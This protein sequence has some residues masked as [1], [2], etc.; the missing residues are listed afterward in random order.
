VASVLEAAHNTGVHV[1]AQAVLRNHVH[2]LVSYL[3]TT[4]LDGF[5]QHAKAE[6]ARRVNVARRDAQRLVWMV[7]YHVGSLSRDHVT[8]TRS[9]IA[10]QFRRHPDLI[11]N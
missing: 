10:R 5:V 4:A 2:V 3:P 8:A 6:A 9:Y 11:P 1:H 7:G